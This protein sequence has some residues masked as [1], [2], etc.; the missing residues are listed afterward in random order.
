MT[1][2]SAVQQF[3]L[4]ILLAILAMLALARACLF[5]VGVSG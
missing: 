4:L 2:P 1:W 3:G 5:G